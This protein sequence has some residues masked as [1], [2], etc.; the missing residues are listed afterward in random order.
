MRNRD[1][2]N[3][4]VEQLYQEV[5]NVVWTWQAWKHLFL[6]KNVIQREQVLAIAPQSTKHLQS[7][8]ADFVLLRLSALCQPATYFGLL[9]VV[10]ALKQ[11]NGTVP[12]SLADEIN[13][14]VRESM[15]VK[16]HRD[17]R[18][19]HVTDNTIPENPKPP[20][21]SIRRMDDRV[22][23]LIKLLNGCRAEL[24]I[25]PTHFRRWA[26]LQPG[27]DLLIALESAAAWREA[28]L[29]AWRLPPD[30]LHAW[31]RNQERAGRRQ[32]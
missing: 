20:P 3:A 28:K 5:A 8:F 17:T 11:A 30:E 25:A 21:I 19:A 24:G 12:K 4:A 27:E 10:R 2:A 29:N 14:F 13:L 32:R 31:L 23:M 1:K 15:D 22:N 18:I 26:M 6:S 9:R 7:V 16:A